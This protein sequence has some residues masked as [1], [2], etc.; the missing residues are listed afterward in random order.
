MGVVGGW[1]VG[2]SQRIVRAREVW[3][4]LVNATPVRKAGAGAQNRG[5]SMQRSDDRR[6]TRT[7]KWALATLVR[8]WSGQAGRQESG[9]AHG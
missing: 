6:D 4:W 8:V 3:G 7:Q 1:V 9:H 5:L 2:R